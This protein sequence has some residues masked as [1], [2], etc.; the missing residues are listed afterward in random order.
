MH[1]HKIHSCMEP[2]AS[3]PWCISHNAK[4]YKRRRCK[5]RRSSAVRSRICDRS[6]RS[7]SYRP[8]R[9]G[10]ASCSSREGWCRYSPT[11]R[12]T[13]CCSRRRSASPSL[14]S[15]RTCSSAWAPRRTARRGCTLPLHRRRRLE[16]RRRPWRN[17]WR[18][19][20][21]RE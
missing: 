7:C 20:G 1:S 11:R 21:R 3:R 18:R 2:Q 15:L 17:E 10:S 12:C 9:S 14:C 5:R 4:G 16:K 6:R 13:R 8:A 19:G